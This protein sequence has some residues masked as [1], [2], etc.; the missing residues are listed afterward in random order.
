MILVAVFLLGVGLGATVTAWVV[1]L[2]RL[3][4]L[5][6]TRDLDPFM[7]PVA[8]VTPLPSK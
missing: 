2:V 4:R 1:L 5:D 8:S 6:D 7:S 3:M